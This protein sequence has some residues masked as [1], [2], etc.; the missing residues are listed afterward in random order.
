FRGHCISAVNVRPSAQL[1][2]GICSTFVNPLEVAARDSGRAYELERPEPIPSLG[3]FGRPMRGS[4]WLNR[5]YGSAI[6]SDGRKVAGMNLNLGTAAV[7]YACAVSDD[8]D[9]G[10]DFSPLSIEP[11]PFQSVRRT[12]RPVL[13]L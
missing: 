9:R 12:C 3:T 2:L 4:S 8:I 5:T 1:P 10:A 11:S 7:R 13:A 6:Q